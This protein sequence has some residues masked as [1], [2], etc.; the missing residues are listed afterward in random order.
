M[1]LGAVKST[2]QATETREQTAR[3]VEI[4]SLRVKQYHRACRGPRHRN[5]AKAGRGAAKTRQLGA[6]WPLA[7]G[8][9]DRSRNQEQRAVSGR[10]GSN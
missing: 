5:L 6:N 3:M 9:L 7:S 8:P 10:H 4:L 1:Q 2:R